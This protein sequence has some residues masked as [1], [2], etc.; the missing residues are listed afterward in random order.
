VLTEAKGSRT[1]A[2]TKNQR[3]A[4]PEIEKSGAT[5]TGKG[6][7]EFTGGTKVPATKVRVRRPDE[8]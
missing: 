5:V 8:L 3:K 4:F 7:G 1:A 2:L 6:K